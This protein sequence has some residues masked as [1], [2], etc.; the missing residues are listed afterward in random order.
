MFSSEKGEQSD[1]LTRFHFGATLKLEG[2]KTEYNET[3]N[4]FHKLVLT[5]GITVDAERLKFDLPRFLPPKT[6]LE[7]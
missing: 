3:V 5:R 7:N 1:D 4:S 2:Q 6:N